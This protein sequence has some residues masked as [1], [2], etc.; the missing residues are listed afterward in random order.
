MRFLK[1]LI[2]RI[3]ARE[4]EKLIY[5]NVNHIRN[6]KPA[7]RFPTFIGSVFLGFSMAV[8]LGTWYGIFSFFEL[9][10]FNWLVP[11]VSGLFLAIHLIRKKY[12]HDM[13]KQEIKV[14]DKRYG[15]RIKHKIVPDYDTLIVLSL[16]HRV[17][18][19]IQGLFIL[20]AI[21]GILYVQ[22]IGVQLN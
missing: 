16:K 4:S 12:V 14:P 7:P 5:R 6:Q 2:Y 13:Q 15:Y 1:Y 10:H 3:A 9:N 11:T 17:Y 22:F 19:S 20:L 8:G 21:A 18:N